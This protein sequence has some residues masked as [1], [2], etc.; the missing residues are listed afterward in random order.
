ME[1]GCKEGN[2]EIS[3]LLGYKQKRELAPKRGLPSEK[4]KQ[5]W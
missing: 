5:E 2:R 1:M 4:H 3:A